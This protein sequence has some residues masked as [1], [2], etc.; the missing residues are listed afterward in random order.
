MMKPTLLFLVALPLIMIVAACK[1][2]VP[3]GTAAVRLGKC[4]VEVF[5]N[6]EVKICYDSLIHESRCPRGVYCIWGGM[7]I[8]KFTFS[9][10]TDQHTLILAPSWPDTIVGNYKIKLLNIDPYPGAHPRPPA[11]AY[12]RITKL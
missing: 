7:A 3:K 2:D 4:S 8:G 6:D 1:K 5:G 12:F 9:V 11:T 10:N